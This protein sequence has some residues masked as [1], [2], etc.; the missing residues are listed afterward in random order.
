MR[1]EKSISDTENFEKSQLLAHLL[2]VISTYR[3]NDRI[4]EKNRWRDRIKKRAERTKQLSS[5]LCNGH[6]SVSTN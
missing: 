6:C 2:E 5:H 1:I 4:R 3:R